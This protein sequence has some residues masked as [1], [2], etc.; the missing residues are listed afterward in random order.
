MF[1]VGVAYG[2]VNYDQEINMLD[3]YAVYV[4]ASGG[5][6]GSFLKEELADYNRDGEVNMQDASALYAIAEG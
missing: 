1:G 2:D 6:T 4:L 5:N 3:A